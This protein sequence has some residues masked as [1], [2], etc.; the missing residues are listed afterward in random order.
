M[1]EL[2][3]R[4]EIGIS[5]RAGLFLTPHT[6]ARSRAFLLS[7]AREYQVGLALITDERS[8][9]ETDRPPPKRL[10]LK[11]KPNFRHHRLVRCSL[12]AVREPRGALVGSP[13][14]D[15]AARAGVCENERGNCHRIEGGSR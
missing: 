1:S 7:R 5:S 8:W 3:F 2:T 10:G 12:R 14:A 15:E 9:D 11:A 13:E 4:L 6:P